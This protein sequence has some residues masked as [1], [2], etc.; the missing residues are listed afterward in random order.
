MA[1]E[2][3]ETTRYILEQNCGRFPGM[4]GYHVPDEAE[5]GGM[6]KM[7]REMLRR[8]MILLEW[9]EFV[10]HCVGYC[11]LLSSLWTTFITGQV[12][13]NF[14]ESLTSHSCSGYS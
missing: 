13:S 7:L 2:A 5:V 8:H 12:M 14:V 4:L 1:F 3:P 11:K 9:E 6:L 10:V